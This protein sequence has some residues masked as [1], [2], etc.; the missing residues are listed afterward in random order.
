MYS[1]I[2]AHLLIL[3]LLGLIFT[4]ITI[5]YDNTTVAI[6]TANT[7]TIET[8]NPTVDQCRQLV[9]KGTVINS[10]SSEGVF[11]NWVLG[12]SLKNTLI[13][14]NTNTSHASYVAVS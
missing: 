10:L 6:I 14:P 11:Q 4:Q 1:K 9:L 3:S 12:T 7:Y 2:N 5:N 13:T 8:T